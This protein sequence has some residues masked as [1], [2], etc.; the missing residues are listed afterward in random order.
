MPELPEV[1]TVRRHLAPVLEGRVITEVDVRR[2]RMAR[3][4]V[5]PSDVAE[6]LHGRTVHRL[7]RHGKFLIA[8]LDHDLR[9]VLHLGMSGRIRLV[10][11]GA[12][13]VP[14]TNVVLWLDQGPEVH[15]VDPRTFGFV[16]AW[17]D[18]EVRSSTLSALGPDAWDAP[19]SA[20][21]VLTRLAGR[22]APIKALLLDQR[23]LAGL[24]NIYA[25]EVL[26]RAGVHPT[27][28]AGSLAPGEVSALLGHVRPVLADGIAAGGTSLD[29]LAYLLP[30]DRAGAYL[31]RLAV[32][33]REGEPCP[34]CGTPV[35]RTVV[36]QRSSHF[37]PRCQLESVS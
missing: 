10:S 29:D 18:E 5:K 35:E 21:E 1:E 30:D 27:R 3:R 13:E 2:D 6:R 33:G 4:N 26:F 16:A 31:S 14:H 15:F 20:D 37:C 34:R 12:P 22:T 25:D 11:P 7:G 24:G 32:Y 28:Q 36:A 9:M 17:T 19:P 23:L 8:T